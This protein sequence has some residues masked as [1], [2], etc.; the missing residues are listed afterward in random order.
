MARTSVNMY[1]D[2]GEPG[3]VAVTI[4]PDTQALIYCCAYPDQAPI[5]SVSHAGVSVDFSASGRA[6]DEPNLVF[7]RQLAANAATY[8]AEC[9]RLYAERSTQT[10]A[11]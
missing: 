8:L 7:A 9:E 4:R 1:M 6:V 10:P 5:M 3:R 2:P 11:A